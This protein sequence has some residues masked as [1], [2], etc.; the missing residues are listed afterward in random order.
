VS[1]PNDDPQQP[2]QDDKAGDNPVP[3]AEE[4]SRIAEPATLRRAPRYRAFVVAGT[5]VGLLIAL[6]LVIIG[7]LR[8]QAGTDAGSGV[9][10]LFVA[11]V[12]GL[13]G[14]AVGAAVAVLVDRRTRRTRRTRR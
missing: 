13:I 2:E 7:A 3:T 1:T 14:A 11:G 10:L 6:V 4:L 9:V 12:L 8:S 5:V